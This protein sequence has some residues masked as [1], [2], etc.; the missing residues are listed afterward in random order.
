MKKLLFDLRLL[1]KCIL[2][3]T[4]QGCSITVQWWLKDE[5]MLM[6]H[7]HTSDFR[8]VLLS[9]HTPPVGP[10]RRLQGADVSVWR[11]WRPALSG[12]QGW[13]RRRHP[14]IENFQDH[15]SAGWLWG[16]RC[17]G[18]VPGHGWFIR[19]SN[20]RRTPSLLDRRQCLGRP[21][22][23]GGGCRWRRSWF[24][25]LDTGHPLNPVFLKCTIFR[26][27]W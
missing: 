3:P 24:I 8:Q 9:M 5:E 15:T 6:K 27:Y 26:L 1:T 10:R 4:M 22:Q 18:R 25:W 23:F 21:E 16:Q 17:W 14:G 20:R 13:S 2:T 12:G 19:R 7:S 11:L